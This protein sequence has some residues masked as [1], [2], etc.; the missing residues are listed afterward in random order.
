[1]AK[2]NVIELKN[3]AFSYSGSKSTLSDIDLSIRSGEF[4]LLCGKSGCGKTTLIRLM[5]G[6]IPHYYSGQSSGKIEIMNRDIR[7]Y[8]LYELAPI[9]STVF[10][11]PKSQFFN[12]NTSSE[13]L[14]GLENINS[15]KEF[16]DSRLKE[17]K[18][19]FKID[20]L[21]DRNIFN[22]SGGEKQIIAIAAAYAMDTAI[23][24]MDEPTSNLDLAS[25]N[26]IEDML[27]KLKSM[28][29]TII[30]SEHRINFLK[31]LI[32]RAI[33]LNDGRIIREFSRDE[34]NSLNDDDLKE[35]GLRSLSSPKA[36]IA[37]ESKKTS[38]Y[39]I[40]SL[41]FKYKNSREN[42]FDIENL[43]LPTNS[44]IGLVGNNGVGKSSFAHTLIGI[45]KANKD[46]IL[47]HE[48]IINYKD[49]LKL[50]YL[51][52]Q[53]VSYQLFTE[54]VRDELSLGSYKGFKSIDCDAILSSLNLKELENSHPLG[55]SGGQKQRV[56]IA[57]GIASGSEIMIF[58]EPTSGMDRYH[59]EQTAELINSLKSENRLIIIITHDLEL[60][61]LVGEKILMMENGN[62]N[63]LEPG[64]DSWNDLINK[65]SKKSS[66]S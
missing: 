66:N 22:L 49:R 29:K 30:I 35:L 11:N 18:K 40:K 48:K 42:I 33:L 37:N 59:M 64:E 53:D 7:D 62:L 50:S 17:I 32:D 13:V 63:F 60:L 34:F 23:I 51:V 44:I 46:K 31:N 2:D 28:G 21:L 8:E 52:L 27:L 19:L 47:R 56:S 4:V 1:M 36:P 61:S 9:A 26:E 38:E 24:L 12:L 41:S 55:L 5:N 65:L 45:A 25:I 20:H 39:R 57:A 58:D 10:Q 16:M 6:L 14:F 54:S 3:V 15:S 43:S